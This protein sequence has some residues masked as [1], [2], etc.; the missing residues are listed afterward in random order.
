MDPTE[1]KTSLRRATLEQDTPQRCSLLRQL[2]A[3]EPD[4]ATFR[5]QL[6]VVEHMR[7][8]EIQRALDSRE[9]CSF[10]FLKQIH[11]EVH[12]DA[13]HTRPEPDLVVAVDQAYRDARAATVRRAAGELLAK[14]G[15]ARAAE[16]R[17]QLRALLATWARL[18]R[19]GPYTPSALEREK[20]VDLER[21]L[22]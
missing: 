15:H 4:N 20:V 13:W 7:C 21:W 1:L 11:G 12:S 5:D 6:S 2:V 22:A 18:E 19:E 17:A 14:L 3:A 8:Q 16:D 9:G 10:G